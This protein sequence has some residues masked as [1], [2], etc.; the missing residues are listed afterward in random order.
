MEKIALRYVNHLSELKCCEFYRKKAGEIF[1]YLLDFENDDVGSPE[2][3]P[4][5]FKNFTELAE[6]YSG[7]QSLIIVEELT[8]EEAVKKIGNVL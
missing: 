7:K 3:Y 1:C 8:P 5:E 2:E 4:T 6:Y